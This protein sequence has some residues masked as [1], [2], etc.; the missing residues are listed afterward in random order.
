M[1]AKACIATLERLSLEAIC[2]AELDTSPED[3]ATLLARAQALQE[4]AEIVGQYSQPQPPIPALDT[5]QC[6]AAAYHW[7]RGMD[8]YW[9]AAHLRVDEAAVHNALP[10]IKSMRRGAS[11]RHQA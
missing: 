5:S 7:H 8:T 11:I 4:A 3:T 6:L 1:D 9:I 10:R 2:S